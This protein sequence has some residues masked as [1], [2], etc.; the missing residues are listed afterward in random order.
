MEFDRYQTTIFGRA[1]R[2]AGP[3]GYVAY[4]PERIPR[5]LDLSPTTVVLL[6]EADA[7]LGRLAGIGQLLRSP[8]RVA[9]GA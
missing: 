9:A 3:H 8:H 7:A 4:F 1:R 6:S 5:T 2:T